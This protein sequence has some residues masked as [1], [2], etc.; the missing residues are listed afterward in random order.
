MSSLSVLVTGGTGFVGSA[1]VEAIQEKHPNWLL[2]VFDLIQPV[3]PREKV[4]YITGDAT[5]TDDVRKA[6]QAA[7]PAVVIHAAGLVPPLIGRYDRSFE[8]IVFNVNVEGTK[9]M[10]SESKRAGVEAF[11]WTSS[12]CC[13][14]DDFR[15][16]Y[17]NI[18]ESWPTSSQSLVYGESKVPASPQPRKSW[19]R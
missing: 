11:V 19:P 15:Y 13:V 7:K 17:P 3:T 10:L 18:D 5:S 16:Q 4:R 1:I 2:T 14:T 6:M 12:C 9:I 8:R